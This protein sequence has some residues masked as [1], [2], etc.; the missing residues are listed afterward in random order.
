MS[1]STLKQV[2]LAFEEADGP[3]SLSTIAHDLNLS[4]ARLESMI[5]YWVR[6]GRI[7]QSAVAGTCANCGVKGECPFVVKLPQAYELVT[8]G[9]IIPLH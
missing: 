7:R 5:Q 2:L 3:V 6:K 1:T 4:Q 9:E 8:A